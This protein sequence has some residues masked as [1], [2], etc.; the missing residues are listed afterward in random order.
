MMRFCAR[1]SLRKMLQERMEK[2]Q[3]LPDLLSTLLQQLLRSLRLR[4]DRLLNKR[5]R[6]SALSE[7]RPLVGGVVAV[8]RLRSERP[9]FQEELFPSLQQ[10]VPRHQ[11]HR[12]ACVQLIANSAT[13]AVCERESNCILLIIQSNSNQGGSIRLLFGI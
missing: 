8:A 3:L 10:R 12:G 7:Q 4:L 6:G 5:L 11:L 1:S 9:G 2:V 13:L